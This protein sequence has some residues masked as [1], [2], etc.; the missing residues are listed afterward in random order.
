AGAPLLHAPYSGYER[1]AMG[2][3]TVIADAGPAPPFD[4]SQHAHA[5]CLSFEFSSGRQHYVVNA[6]VD[7][8][9]PDDYRPLARA[10]AAHS[11]ATINDSSSARFLLPP[12]L[13]GLLG[14][15]LHAGPGKV[16]CIRQDDAGRQSFVASHNGYVPRFGLFHERELAL[17]HEGGVIDGTDRFFRPGGHAA[18]DNGR[19]AIAI[20]FHLHPDTELYQDSAD[21]L[22]LGASGADYWMFSCDGVVPGVE[23]SIFFAAIGGPRR[24]RQIVLTFKASAI[25]EMQ[26]RFTRTRRAGMI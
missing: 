1:L 11:T 23:E 19:D 26:W 2:G 3:T 20:R 10:T 9:G 6:G 12:R 25:G 22:V 15:P 4:V 24:T 13:R 21:R 14:S 16:A 18:R 8:F 17:S 5:G 7:V